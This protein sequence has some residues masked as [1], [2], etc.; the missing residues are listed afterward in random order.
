VKIA[1][2]AFVLSTACLSVFILALHATELPQIKIGNG[3]G[4]LIVNGQPFLIFG[5]ELGNSSAGTAAQADLIVPKLTVMHV[6][7]ILMPVAWEQIEPKEGSFDF[8]ILDHWIETARAQNMH[9]V[10]L[11]FGSWKNA[12]SNYAP[13][14]VKSDTKR[15]PRAESAD[16][17]PLEI[18]STFSPENR[19]CDSRAFAALI[20]HAREKDSDQQTVL[21]VQV[22]NEVGYLGSGR[23]RS[24]EANRIFHGPVPDVLIRTL[25][26]KRL[27]LSPELAAHFNEHGH[28]WSEVFGG[29]ADEVFM[30]WTYAGYIEAV[31]HAGKSEY[32]LP[33]YVNAQLP[34]PQERAGE[35]PSG[36]PHPYYLEVW[37]AAAPSIDF[38]SPDIYWPNFEYWVQRYEVPSNPIFIPE[39][40]MES[41]PYNALYAYGQARAFGFS[42]FA[43]DGLTP[44]VKDDAPKPEMMQTYE[45]LDSIGDILVTAQAAG[46]TRGLVLHTTSPRPTQTV[47]LGGYLFE[48]TLSRSWP[49]RTII[50]DDGAML[51]L[52]TSPGEFYIVGSGL[53]VSFARD[54]DVDTGNVGIESI[55]QVSR[56]SGRWTT[57]MRLNGDQTNQGRQLLLD[58]H[59]QHI[60][61]LRLYSITAEREH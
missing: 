33:M 36:G 37:R 34:A 42:P 58:P 32:A 3:A 49:A 5:G 44:P 27:Q 13:S 60:Y 25:T 31:A 56:A 17:R 28:T 7:T 1:L 26:A 10:L 4:Q 61:R 53:T 45:L 23:D 29:A 48:A 51:I 8:S 14:W 43:I 57:E 50:A 41:A 46:L 11:W 21:M 16:G 40:R 15:F 38:Y 59:R 24:P 30:A 12:L 18:L 55:E 52:Q 39:V 47:A 35:Y 22:E 19:R 20:R 9:L 6:N 54:P 2:R